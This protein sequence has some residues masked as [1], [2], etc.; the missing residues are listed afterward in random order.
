M[1]TLK[2]KWK[3]IFAA[4]LSAGLVSC[5]EI[6]T[7]ISVLSGGTGS[8]SLSAFEVDEMRSGTQVTCSIMGNRTVRCL[9]SN[10]RGDLGR[11]FSTPVE[12]V[13][14]VQSIALGNRFSCFIEGEKLEV[15]CF[16]INDKGQLGNPTVYESVKP[17]PVIDVESGNKPL[18]DAKS[19]TAGENH[20]CALLKTGRAVCWG[21]NTFGQS[22]NPSLQGL[23]LKTIMENERTPKPFQGI[24]EIAAGGNST[25][26]VAKD[27]RGVYC[28]GERYGAKKK[29]NWLPEPVELAGSIGN[30]SQVKQIGVGREFGCA[31]GKSSQVYCWGRNDLNQLGSQN[32]MPGVTKATQVQISFPIQ[33]PL[34]KVEQLTVGEYHACGLHRDEQTLFCWGDNRYGQLGNTSL[35]G[36]PEQVALGSNNLTLKGVRKAV[37]GVDRTCIISS[38]DEVFCWGNGEDGILG[39]EKVSSPYPV[40]ALDEKGEM[41]DST[42][43]IS[44]GYD[45]SCTLDAEKKLYC[46]GRNSSGQMGSSLVAREALSENNRTIERVTALDTFHLRSCMVHGESQSV[47]CFGGRKIDNLLEKAVKNSFIPE[48]VKRELSVYQNATGVVV[49]RAHL[50]VIT[51]EQNV[52]CQGDGALGQLG[53]GDNLTLKF[54]TVVDDRSRAL[55]DV[56]QADSNGDFNCALKQETG[57]VWC[58][59]SWKGQQWNQA[60]V[61]SMSDRPSNDFIQIVLSEDQICGVRGMERALFCTASSAKN[62][63][64]LEF[65][66][67]VDLDG[68]QLKKVMSLT[69]GKRHACAVDEEGR[70]YCWGQNQKNQLGLKNYSETQK[71]VRVPFQDERLKHALRVSAGDEHTC[72]TVADQ[73]SVFCFGQSIFGTQFSPEPVEYPL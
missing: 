21:D 7:V 35:R 1:V 16:G 33:G 65:Q 15:K 55:N 9:G 59:G 63:D 39:S 23:M 47:S 22:G 17:V 53:S 6:R 61:I 12:D 67:Q 13:K 64:S 44:L 31:L 2:R 45:H 73:T 42:L 51:A 30:L 10:V 29:H 43:D 69:A 46:F 24:Q 14:N 28:F 54:G 48:E 37:A 25:C 32:N 66:P 60:R 8:L 49:G 38:R 3:L 34:N 68:K 19:I 18:Q 4:F 58:W 70:V 52:E 40:R 62:L 71:A 57:S 41:L 20:A 50:C 26:L 56:W 5:T 11:F 72:M 27:F 36:L